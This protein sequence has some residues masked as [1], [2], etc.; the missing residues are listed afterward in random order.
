MKA[1][2]PSSCVLFINAAEHYKKGKRQNVLLPEHIDRIV[3]TY[4]NRLEKECYARRVSMAEIAKN[5]CNLTFPAASALPRWKQ[6][7][8]CRQLMPNWNSWRRKSKP[9]RENIMTFSESLACPPCRDR[10]P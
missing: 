3:E 7:L 1:P 5:D 2:W 6:R 4:Q 10:N 9:Q 8:I